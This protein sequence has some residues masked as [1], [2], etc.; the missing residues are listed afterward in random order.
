MPK[1]RL[2]YRSLLAIAAIVL[3]LIISIALS[4]GMTREELEYRPLSLS[5]VTQV[6]DQK[7]LTL[8]PFEKEGFKNAVLFG[9]EP[10]AYRI[11]NTEDLVFIYPFSSHGEREKLVGHYWRFDSEMMNIFTPYSQLFQ[12]FA[13]KNMF[14]VYCPFVDIETI[15]PEELP[16]Y[17]Y[18]QRS[19]TIS[20]LVFRDLNGGKTLI[21]RGEGQYWEVE[22]VFGYFNQFYKDGRGV[23]GYHSQYQRNTIARYKGKDPTEVG[24]FNFI[25]KG[26]RSTQTGEG[27]TLDSDGLVRLGGGGGGG[28]GLVRN[29]EDT[30]TFTVEWNGK[31]EIFDLKVHPSGF[32]LIKESKI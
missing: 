9:V 31:K 29:N 25:L 13:A 2:P 16:N 17:P 4:S 21:F 7:G 12:T 10:K 18:V 32:A 14:I 6:F 8:E 26:S 15:K 3:L 30:Y 28:S 23:L 11:Q 22:M 1:V 27:Y 5:E 20:K 24:L 19:K